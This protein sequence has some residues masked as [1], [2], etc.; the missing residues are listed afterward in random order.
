M[1]SGTES[2]IRGSIAHG[3]LSCRG[4]GLRNRPSIPP[5][6]LH[7]TLQCNMP[8]CYQARSCAVVCGPIATGGTCAT[9]FSSVL[10]PERVVTIAAK[11]EI[12]YLQ[13]LDAEGKEVRKDLPAF[14]KDLDHMVELYKLML[15]TRVFDAKSVADRK[16]TRLNSSHPSISYA[17]F[18]LKKKK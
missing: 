17:V 4:F 6:M 14:A 5:R 8:A 16:S 2:G 15:S 12:E 1:L 18:C 11:F 9:R 3:V 13:Y 7:C 10:T